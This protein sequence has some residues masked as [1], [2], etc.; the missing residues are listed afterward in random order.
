MD[1]LILYF[2]FKK[3]ESALILLF[4]FSKVTDVTEILKISVQDEKKYD[5]VGSVA[6]PLL[7][8]SSGHKVWHAL[9]DNTLRERA[10]G[11]NPRILLEMRIS[12]NLVSEVNLIASHKER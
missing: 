6:I 4:Y 11:N 1:S 9:K 10:K 3:N 12:W 7:R 2:T 5:E 8:I